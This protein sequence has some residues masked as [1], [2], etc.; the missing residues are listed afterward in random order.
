M[1]MVFMLFTSASTPASASSWSWE[2]SSGLNILIVSGNAFYSDAASM[3]TFKETY[4]AAGN[5]VTVVESYDFANFAS[6]NYD[7][8]LI[9]AIEGDNWFNAAN[10]T[11]IVDWF[12]DGSKLLWVAGNSD[13]GGFYQ[14]NSTSNPVL[15]AVKSNLRIDGGA[16]EDPQSSDGS[17]YRVIANE[18][19]V[20]STL[21]DYVTDPGFVAIFH[22]PTAVNFYDYTASEFKDLRNQTIADYDIDIVANAFLHHMVRNIAGV[23]MAIGAGEHP[24]DWSREVLEARDRTQ[25]GITAPPHGL[26]LVDVDYAP[27]YEL[28]RVLHTHMIW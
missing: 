27:D 13:Y 1:V 24:V 7:A 12:D 21:T 3:D 25:A 16:I 18:T 14:S 10:L 26:Y 2:I 9:S 8:L 4:E 5:N 15:E 17:A 28:P 11:E 22:G 6:S 23:L 19:G 20:S